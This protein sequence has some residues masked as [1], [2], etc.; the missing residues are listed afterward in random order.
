MKAKGC[1][2]SKNFSLVENSFKCLEKLLSK[3][4]SDYVKMMITITYLS[5]NLISHTGSHQL[6]MAHTQQPVNESISDVCEMIDKGNVMLVSIYTADD[7]PLIISDVDSGFSIC[8]GNNANIYDDS[9]SVSS[10]NHHRKILKIKKNE[11][12]ASRP[13]K[14]SG[15]LLKVVFLRSLDRSSVAAGG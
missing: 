4:M 5:L 7:R 11:I 10:T 14:K 9:I 12:V 2:K 6:P 13:L 3:K 1:V 8:I 15:N